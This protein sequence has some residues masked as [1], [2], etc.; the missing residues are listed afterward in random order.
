MAS[1][2][3]AEWPALDPLQRHKKYVSLQKEIKAG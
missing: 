3:L 2:E 1:V